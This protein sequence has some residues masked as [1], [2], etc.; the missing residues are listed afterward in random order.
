MTDMQHLSIYPKW[1]IQRAYEILEISKNN[2]DTNGEG[3]MG[4]EIILLVGMR[5]ID[6]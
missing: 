2:K 5:S 1:D 3:C 4:K 6:M